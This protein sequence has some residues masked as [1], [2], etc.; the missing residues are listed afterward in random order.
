MTKKVD[1][2]SSKKSSGAK[3]PLFVFG[4]DGTGKPIGARFAEG[5]YDPI[6]CVAHELKCSMVHQHSK[7]F[8]ELGMRLPMGRIYAS[9]KAFIPNIRQDLFDKLKEAQNKPGNP[10]SPAPMNIVGASVKGPSE[11][12]GE[13]PTHTMPYAGLPRTWDSVQAGHMVLI[14]ESPEDGWWEALVVDR[15]DDVLTLR[16]RDYPKQPVF[17]RHVSNVA[18]V[19]PGPA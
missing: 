19:N 1:K 15:K 5:I 9:G 2:T 8:D 16:F 18:L 12:P 11:A 17:V 3:D 6:I 7:E 4:L 14:H 10:D 13:E